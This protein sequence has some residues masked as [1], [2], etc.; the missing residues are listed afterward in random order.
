VRA[1]QP[2]SAAD[3]AQEEQALDPTH[4]W[5]RE[6]VDED[7]ADNMVRLAEYIA[8]ATC[9]ATDVVTHTPDRVLVGVRWDGGL[10]G[11]S[12]TK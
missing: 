6:Q 3:V 8:R 12:R 10:I 5:L 2:D 4:A 7:T 9:H 1:G 11:F